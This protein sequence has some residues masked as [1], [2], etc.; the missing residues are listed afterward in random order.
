MN[1]YIEKRQYTDYDYQNN[2][3]T[4]Y[5]KEVE[6]KEKNNAIQELIWNLATDLSNKEIQSYGK[7]TNDDDILDSFGTYKDYI[8]KL[9][10]VKEI[11]LLINKYK[12]YKTEFASKLV[13]DLNKLKELLLNKKTESKS[14]KLV[15][16]FNKTDYGWHNNETTYYGELNDGNYYECV[17]EPCYMTIY[18]EPITKRYLDYLYREDDEDTEL[19]A[20]FNKFN[21]EHDITDKYSYD[22]LCNIEAEINTD[23]LGYKDLDESKLEEYNEGADFGKYTRLVTEIKLQAEENGYKL[24]D[25][26]I[27]KIADKMVDED[28]FFYDYELPD[29]DDFDDESWKEIHNVINDYLKSNKVEEKYNV[30]TLAGEDGVYNSNKVDTVDTIEQA[31]DRV[32]ELRAETGENAYYEEVV[33]DKD[34]EEELYTDIAKECLRIIQEIEDNKGR[35]EIYNDYSGN[36]NKLTDWNDETAEIFWNWLETLDSDDLEEIYND[37]EYFENDDND[38]F[39]ESARREDKDKDEVEE[40]VAA[41]IYDA[42]NDFDED[43]YENTDIDEYVIEDWLDTYFEPT[44]D[45]YKSSYTDFDKLVDII[46]E[47]FWRNIDGEDMEDILEENEKN[48]EYEKLE[49]WEDYPDNII[50]DEL[51]YLGNDPEDDEIL[52][53]G[54]D[55]ETKIPNRM[56]FKQWD[57]IINDID[58]EHNL[59]WVTQQFFGKDE[60]EQF[61]KAFKELPFDKA[62]VTV[63]DL[64]TYQFN[65]DEKNK[66]FVI[67]NN[68]GR[69]AERINSYNYENKIKEIGYDFDY[70]T[71]KWKDED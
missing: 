51:N 21:E 7:W 30:Y 66:V 54:V 38:I 14:T 17:A 28:N 3:V 32:A 1:N 8:N 46:V 60:V 70:E 53:S 71:G 49:E 58:E 29:P 56:R 63:R 19:E 6:S 45:K 26:D 13:D 68:H 18:D 27:K 24:S 36:S 5:G 4:V 33:D 25:K 20:Y 11:D 23:Y 22:D 61:A 50:G 40:Y 37:R 52:F 34:W 41:A 65:E 44:Y 31:E 10:S 35:I 69:A 59:Y 62:Y 47:A 15:K 43:D 64:S 39:L 48:E 12:N 9:K 16:T 57:I 55:F 67:I 2:A 42:Y